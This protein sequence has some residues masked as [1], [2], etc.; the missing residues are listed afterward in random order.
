[1]GV[2]EGVAG[3]TVTLTAIFAGLAAPTIALII[4]RTDRKHVML[5]VTG[6]VIASN[7]LAALSWGFWSLL[8]ARVIMGLAI[9][10]FFALAGATIARL[11]SI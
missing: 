2:S 11:V 6:L 10:G 7:L 5:T 8:A 9:G 3:Q 1:M 4:G